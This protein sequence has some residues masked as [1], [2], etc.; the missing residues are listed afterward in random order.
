MVPFQFHVEGDRRE[1]DK[2]HKGDHLLN[3]LE[4][5]QTERTAV[6]FETDT[7]RRHLQAVLKESDA[8]G[9]QDH[10]DKRCG[11]GEEPGLLQFEVTV[12]RE[13]HED[14]RR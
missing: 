14:I 4:L 7:V 5:H 6:P 13:R 11:I 9:E 12:P 3:D 10:K 2:D 8:P 1:S